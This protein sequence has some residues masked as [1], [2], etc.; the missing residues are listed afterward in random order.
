MT[1]AL[2]ERLASEAHAE[3]KAMAERARRLMERRFRT[4][5]RSKGQLFRKRNAK[6]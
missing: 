5:R 3:I 1:D 4:I 2:I 6:E